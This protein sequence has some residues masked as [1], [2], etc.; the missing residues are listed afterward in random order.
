MPSFLFP[1]KRESLHERPGGGVAEN[2][3]DQNSHVVVTDEAED[4]IAQLHRTITGQSLESDKE[5]KDGGPFVGFE[6]YL[7]RDEKTRSQYVPLSVCFKSL[8]T[9]GIQEDASS[10]KTLKDAIIRT[11]TLQDIYEMT[12]KRLISPVRMEDGRPLIRDFT[13]L[14]RNGEMML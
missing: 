5:D 2:D 13:G 11:F 7:R 1:P 4:T 3:G 6:N 9:Y 12:L 14:V 10:A 8:T